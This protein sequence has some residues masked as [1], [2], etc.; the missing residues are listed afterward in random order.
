[1]SFKKSQKSKTNIIKRLV[2]ASFF[3]AL[4]FVAT[5][6]LPRIPTALGY[7]HLGD[8]FVLIASSCLPLPYALASAAVGGALADIMTG[9]AVYAP[10]TMIIKL[11][12]ALCISSRVKKLVAPRN[13]IGTAA[14]TL[15][16][17]GG[18]YL[19]EALAMSGS[20]VAPLAD[21]PFNL[22]QTA[23]GGVI[24]VC[25]GILFDRT[26]ALRSM[27]PSNADSQQKERIDN[28]K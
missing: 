9:Y 25:I 24:F 23:V 8:G 13:L 5:A 16:N 14:A 1:M 22:A 15:I 26:P 28:V 3:S 10:A 12:M 19:Y 21:L 11:L 2:F 27:L 17:A 7:I 6:Y 20:F 18:Y 4:I